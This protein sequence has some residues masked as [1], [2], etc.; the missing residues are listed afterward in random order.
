MRRDQPP[1]TDD[2]W[3]PVLLMSLATGRNPKPPLS[4]PDCQP[5]V[6]RTNHAPNGKAGP[7]GKWPPA[8]WCGPDSA[9]IQAPSFTPI[10]ES[11][12]IHPI[13][14][15]I[16]CQASGIPPGHSAVIQQ[17][18]SVELS[19]SL[20]C[21]RSSPTATPARPLHR[22]YR[23]GFLGQPG[24]CIHAAGVSASARR[25]TAG[26]RKPSRSINHCWL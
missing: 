10:R 19:G 3:C 5:F 26:A 17:S 21:V 25:T 23:H 22:L 1:A 13:G 8:T 2:N 9:V 12:R 24:E 14:C 4:T 7:V 11:T 16:G 18:L 6:S 20:R 15:Q